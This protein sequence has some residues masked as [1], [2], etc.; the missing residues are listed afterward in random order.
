MKECIPLQNAFDKL[1]CSAEFVTGMHNVAVNYDT[2]KITSLSHAA[3]SHT[4]LG[5][6]CLYYLLNDTRFRA[7][8]RRIVLFEAVRLMLGQG[9]DTDH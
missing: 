1:R 5:I 6:F 7:D 3:E 4:M 8:H 9:C 2:F